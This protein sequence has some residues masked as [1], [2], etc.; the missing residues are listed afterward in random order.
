MSQHDFDKKETDISLGFD[1]FRWKGQVWKDLDLIEPS[2]DIVYHPDFGF[3][4]AH[5]QKGMNVY[6]HAR[7]MDDENNCFPIDEIR[8]ERVGNL[9]ESIKHFNKTF[10]PDLPMGH[11]VRTQIQMLIDTEPNKGMFCV[12]ERG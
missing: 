11:L 4:R 8:T 12:P 9:M 5:K 10:S 6:L 3:G 1:E 7:D 2:V